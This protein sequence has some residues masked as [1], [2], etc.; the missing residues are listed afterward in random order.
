MHIVPLGYLYVN[1]TGSSTVHC[2]LYPAAI[3]SQM[4]CGYSGSPVCVMLFLCEVL[5]PVGYGSRA[6]SSRQLD[7]SAQPVVFSP[8]L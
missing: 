3:S 2:K 7:I 6:D 1:L 4:V 8:E 5:C